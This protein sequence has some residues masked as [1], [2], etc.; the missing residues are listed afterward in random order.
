[1][2]LEPGERIA[3]LQA[4]REWPKEDG[5]R[6]VVMGTRKGVVKRTDLRA[7][8][9][10]RSGGIIAIKVGADDAVI[11]AELTDGQDQ[12]FIGTQSGKAIRFLE[13]N[14]R[15]MGR[16]AAGVRGISRKENDE[17]VAMAIVRPNG[18]LLTVTENGF[19]KR[20]ALKEYRVQKRGGVG[21]INI[22]AS[23]R[24]GLVSGIAYVEQDDEL[25][26]ITQQG[27]IIRMVT[28]DIRPIGRA[29]QGVRLIEID[30]SDRVVSI[31]RLAEDT[32]VN[33][34][35]GDN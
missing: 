19:G 8:R 35:T 11:G 26:L 34:K 28:S 6:F 25:M 4:V 33:L 20:T 24:N 5:E 14:V 16:T 17:V 15:A 2:S 7:F 1:V 27:K 9:H 3:I 18:T 30:D 12:I 31:A 21:I 23:Q 10:P 32:L 22:Q 13:T 29:T